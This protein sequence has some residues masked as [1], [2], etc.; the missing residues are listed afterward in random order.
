MAKAPEDIFAPTTQE[1]D[2]EPRILIITADGTEDTEFFYPYYRFIETGCAVDVATPHGA[3]KGKNGSGLKKTKTLEEVKESDY[4]LLYIPGGKAPEALKEE[5][6]AIELVRAF[7]GSGKSIAA[8][9]HGPQLL[10][11]ADVIKDKAIAGWPEIEDEITKAGA[12]FMNEECIEDGLFIT[13]RWPGDLPA[14]TRTVMARLRGKT[15][16]RRAA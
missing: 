5:A 15:S 4:T 10:A 16:Q 7:A 1:M 9:C 11:K 12:S 3:F 2:V 14:F 6:A 8:I 13:S